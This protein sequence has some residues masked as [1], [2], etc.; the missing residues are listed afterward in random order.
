MTTRQ[1]AL[2]DETRLA[3]LRGMN[4]LADAVR[5]TLGPGGRNVI[6]ER[7]LA[8]PFFTRDGA[9]VAEEISLVDRQENLGAQ[10][11]REAAKRTAET[12]GDG[13]TTAIVLA[14]SIFSRAL[15]SVTVGVDPLAV[16][17]GIDKAVACVI[18]EVRRLSTPVPLAKIAE[19]AVVSANGDRAIAD[20]IA[21]AL[22]EVGHDGVVL[23]QEGSAIQTEL[24][25]VQ[26]LQFDR[27]YLSPY[28]VTNAET[29]ECILE[30]PRILLA[31]QAIRGAG[32]LLAIMEKVANASKPLL[33]VAQDVE[34]EALAMLV[35]NRV[36]GT[37]SACAIKAPSFGEQQRLQLQDIGVLTGAQVVFPETGVRLDQ[38]QMDDLGEAD[39]VVVNQSKTT[40][41]GGRGKRQQIEMRI[42]QIRGDVEKADRGTDRALLEQRLAKLAGG[43]AIIQVGAA[44]ETEMKERKARTENALRACRAAM[45]RGVVPGGG[46]ALVRAARSLDSMRLSGGEEVGAQVVASACQEPLKQIARN[47]GHDQFVVLERVR[48]HDSPAFGFNAITGEYEDLSKT[49]VIDPTKV[50]TTAL[51]NAASVAGLLLRTGV[52]IYQDSTIRGNGSTL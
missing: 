35:V 2:G 19:V 3:M 15:K 17:R 28:F 5:I 40:I 12:A 44:T 26:G 43:V 7:G 51:Q 39:K 6:L 4:R 30:R 16:R 13:T 25:T 10:V 50:V 23:V 36:R 49:G 33:I 1:I 38:L 32:D 29:M 48:Q 27:G 11:I 20:V 42:R 14:Q 31:G 46:V 41:V 45:E 24:E 22:K 9:S 8:S 21:Q 37:L 52:S 34:G 47:A 18:E